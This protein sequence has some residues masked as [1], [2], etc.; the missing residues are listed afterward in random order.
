MSDQDRNEQDF[1]NELFGSEEEVPEEVAP[2]APVQPKSQGRLR[3]E[4]IENGYTLEDAKRVRE[5]N[6]LTEE[7]FKSGEWVSHPELLKVVRNAE[8]VSITQMKRAFGGNRNMFDPISPEWQVKRRG[9]TRYHRVWCLTDEAMDVLRGI[10]LRTTKTYDS[11]A[12]VYKDM[13]KAELLVV[14]AEHE[15]EVDP[16]LKKAQIIETIITELLARQ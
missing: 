10:A 14:A 15:V 6:Q 16:K 13:T 1:V 11:K 9:R 7:E 12:D 3:K 4:L 8:G 2:T 5:E